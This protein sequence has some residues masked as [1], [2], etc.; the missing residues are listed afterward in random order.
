[1]QGSGLWQRLLKRRAMREQHAVCPVCSLPLVF[2]P[3]VLA[4]Q[5]PRQG[6]SLKMS[7]SFTPSAGNWPSAW[8]RWILPPISNVSRLNKSFRARRP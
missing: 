5:I 8:A 1:M 3:G 7:G 4:R 2:R 6:S